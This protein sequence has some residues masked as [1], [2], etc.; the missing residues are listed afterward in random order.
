MKWKNLIFGLTLL[1]GSI[2]F[3]VL[4]LEVVL[5]LAGVSYPSFHKYDE[6]SGAALRPGAKGF[7]RKEGNAYI[8][9]NS[10]GW[11]DRERPLTKP[12]KTIRIAILG[13]SYAEA[14]QLPMADAFWSVLERELEK[15]VQPIGLGIEVLN[16]GVSGYGTA[17]ELN[18]LRHRV[19]DYSPEIVILAFVSGND[20]R[21]NSRALEGDPMRP[22]FI[23]KDDELVLDGSFRIS[24]EFRMR[25]TLIARCI[26]GVINY[27]RTLQ[28]LN[29]F[30]NTVEAKR[31]EARVKNQSI[32]SD[33]VGI[34]TAVYKP[35][36][37]QEWQEAWRVTE[38]LIVR[39]HEEVVQRKAEFWVVTLT[40]ASQVHPDRAVREEIA[41]RLGVSDLFYPDFRIKSLCETENIPVLI[42]APLFR[43]YAE[44]H[45][46]YLHGF[47][48]ATMGG[49]HW[50]ANGHRLADELIAA[51]LM[52]NSEK[53]KRLFRR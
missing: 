46:I 47:K 49:G 22:Y 29:H 23:Y 32:Q 7:W 53:V 14:L 33:E 15:V 36:Q 12:S 27:S 6:Y 16:F 31:R 30:K 52:K 45:K 8:V 1:F 25:Q 42:L 26:Y 43:A 35:P 37:T 3:T 28:I 44:E 13:D 51:E 48:N 21:N 4:C 20:V 41:Q 24:P 50:N 38:R 5:R 19:W 9:I 34:D 11:R 18:T 17:Q 40:N 10:H 2:L 39:M